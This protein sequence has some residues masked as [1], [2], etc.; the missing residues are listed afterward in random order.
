MKRYVLVIFL[1]FVLNV[2]LAAF[3]TQ[4]MRGLPV[5]VE[6]PELAATE[7]GGAGARN[8]ILV[9]GDGMG[10]EHVR[11][12]RLYMGRDL[13][14]EN[15]PYSGQMATTSMSGVTDSAAGATAMATGRRVRNGVISM[16]LPGDGAPLATALER[17]QALGAWTGL[18]TTSMVN[19]ATPA[20][21]G[22]HAPSRYD[23][24]QIA[25]YYFTRTR[26][27]VLMGGMDDGVTVEAATAAGYTVATDAEALQ[28]L[29]MDGQ[30]HVA[31]LFGQGKMTI[32]ATQ[33]DLPTLAQMTTAALDQLEEAPA[34]FFLLVE[35]EAT[36]TYSHRNDF[37]AVVQAVVALDE[38]VAAAVTWREEQPEGGEET[39]IVVTADHETGGLLVL[40]DNG[41]GVLPDMRWTGGAGHT[42]LPVPIYGSGPGAALIPSV[43]DITQI[44]TLLTWRLEE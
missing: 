20:A 25:D 40:G 35:Q 9:V 15:F 18:V 43:E 4:G 17:R 23:R 11:A 39:L 24:A 13:T 21:F 6:G 16:A 10:Q 30:T 19:D 42:A 12:T 38:A 1:L 36:D 33:E 26:P 8:V 31:G 29:N 44:A 28:A 7:D 34:G 3:S 5:S 37:E 32:P 27:N 41:A 22:A 2:V 14:F